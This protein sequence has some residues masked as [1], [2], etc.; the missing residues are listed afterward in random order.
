MV[1]VGKQKPSINLTPL[2]TLDMSEYR[3]YAQ[4]L[5]GNLLRRAAECITNGENTFAVHLPSDSPESGIYAA[6]LLRIAQQIDPRPTPK[7][8]TS[9]PSGSHSA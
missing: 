2:Q 4:A 7:S 9:K 3:R 1:N 5:A 6:S 8:W